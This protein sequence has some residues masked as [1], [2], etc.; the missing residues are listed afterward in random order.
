AFDHFDK[1]DFLDALLD[2][3][4]ERTAEVRHELSRAAD[5]QF[6][7]SALEREQVVLSSWWRHPESSSASGTP[8][9]W[10]A[11]PDLKVVELHCRCPPAVAVARFLARQRHPGHLDALR[12]PDHLAEQFACA[13][14]HGPL[15]PSR[16]IV[17]NTEQHVPHAYVV[18]LAADVLQCVRYQREA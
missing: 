8:V 9:S 18:A 10:L 15:F 14:A 13:A 2:V 6:Q 17:C 3:A 5:E 12:E 16:A 4:A 11:A 7:I 1:D